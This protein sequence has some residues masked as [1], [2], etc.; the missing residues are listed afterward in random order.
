[1]AICV[2]F[3][4]VCYVIYF[5]RGGFLISLIFRLGFGNFDVLMN[6]LGIFVK[7][8]SNSGGLRQGLRFC[9]PNKLKVIPMIIWGPYFEK[10]GPRLHVTLL[11]ISLQVNDFLMQKAKRKCSLC[12]LSCSILCA[13]YCFSSLLCNFK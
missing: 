12:S 9:I 8:C 11:C 2:S 7:P 5:G 1:M 3:L 6:Y 13:V 4:E 10:Q